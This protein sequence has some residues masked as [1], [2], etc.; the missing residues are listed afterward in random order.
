VE[1]RCLQQVSAGHKAAFR[2]LLLQ[3]RTKIGNKTYLAALRKTFLAK[4]RLALTM[5]NSR[6]VSLWDPLSCGGIDPEPLFRFTTAGCRTS[7]AIPTHKSAFPIE[8]LKK[9]VGGDYGDS[10]FPSGGEDGREALFLRRVRCLGQVLVMLCDE[11]H[12]ASLVRLQVEE[13]IVRRLLV[14]ERAAGAPDRA[15]ALKKMEAFIAMDCTLDAES[16]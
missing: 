7:L 16:L 15:A 14:L 9:I 3:R 11:L 8:M 10:P 13:R 4:E 2:A 5:A 12:L 6:V 1:S